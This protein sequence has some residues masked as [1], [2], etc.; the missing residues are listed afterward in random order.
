MKLFLWIFKIYGKPPFNSKEKYIFKKHFYSFGVFTLQS[1]KPGNSDFNIEDRIIKSIYMFFISIAVPPIIEPFSFQDG[2]A[3]GMRTR[4]VC[5]V[6]RGD[7]PLYLN[8]LKDNE[9]IPST[10]G[11]N[12][13]LIDQY[14]SLLSIPFLTSQHTG[15]YTCVA[16]NSASRTEFTATLLVKGWYIKTLGGNSAIQLIKFYLKIWI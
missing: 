14:S 13:T 11:L 5:G 6:S 1:E 8:W 15:E 4:T 9:P 16:N 12:I 3:E 2:L 10:L 7:A